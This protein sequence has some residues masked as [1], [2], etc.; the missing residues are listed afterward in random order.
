MH[1]LILS[2][3]WPILGHEHAAKTVLGHLLKTF[4]E[5]G[6]KVSFAVAHPEEEANKECL[7]ILKDLGMEFVGDFTDE[8]DLNDP[9]F[10]TS[11]KARLLHHAQT[12]W[13]PLTQDEYPKFISSYDSAARLDAVGADVALMFWDSWFEHLITDMDKTP[14]FGYLARPRTEAGL[15]RSLE[16]TGGIKTWL[17][18]KTFAARR[19]RHF[20]RV[21]HLKDTVN[22]CALDASW[23]RENNIPCSYLP[24]TWPDAFGDDAWDLRLSAQT[25]REGVQILGNIGHLSATGNSFGIAYT[26]QEVLP[27]L[28]KL[29]TELTWEINICGGGKLRPEVKQ[30]VDYPKINLRGFVDDIDKEILSNEIFLLCNNAGHY[31]GGYTRVMYVM[32]SAGCLIAHKKL[33]VSMPE[34]IHD[35][36]CLLGDNAEQIAY[37]INIA[38]R[39]ESLRQRIGAKA[40]QTYKS[41][42]SPAA[43][44]QGL[45][46][47]FEEKL[48]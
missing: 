19:K 47:I 17:E 33:A 48:K 4:M 20:L 1:V 38:A 34:L 6:H 16:K 43:V 40:R 7:S 21:K 45:V 23:Y 36:N 9:I 11:R 32:S 12:L 5:Q 14:V 37:Y 10:S 13:S 18:R 41:K 2:S 28:E 31:T 27:H 15:S 39:D 29:M 26:I 42:Y 25:K 30:L 22:I 46:H 8:M 3:N 44:V 24:N 35:E